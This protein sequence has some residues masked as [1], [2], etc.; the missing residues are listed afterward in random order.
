MVVRMATAEGTEPKDGLGHRGIRWMLKS[1]RTG[2]LTVFQWPTIP[3]SIFIVLTV[4][5]H[6]IH[7]T[8]R[9]GNLTHVLA[10]AALLVWAVDEVVRGVNPFRRILGALVIVVTIRSLTL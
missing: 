9:A 6:I 7:T 3:L 8:G 2:R 10:G 4:G 5:R 1:R